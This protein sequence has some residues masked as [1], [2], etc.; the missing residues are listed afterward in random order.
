[1]KKKAEKEFGEATRA[2]VYA[3]ANRSNPK[4]GAWVRAFLEVELESRTLDPELV[5]AMKPLLLS[6]RDRDDID[7][8]ASHFGAGR[9][10]ATSRH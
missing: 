8:F 9:K 1:M 7:R 10:T 6:L 3:A 5:A 2:S 4:V